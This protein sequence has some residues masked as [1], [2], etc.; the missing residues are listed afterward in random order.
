MLLIRLEG[1]EEVKTKKFNSSTIR[2]LRSLGQPGKMIESQTEELDEKPLIGE[3]TRVLVLR[4]EYLSSPLQGFVAG[5]DYL[6]HC[7]DGMRAIRGDGNCFY[8]AILFGNI[9]ILLHFPLDEIHLQIG[10][11]EKLLEH[12]LS[13][14]Q[15]L[16]KVAETERLRLIE[17][18]RCNYELLIALGYSEFTIEVFYE[19]VMSC[20]VFS[21]S[22]SPSYNDSAGIFRA[23]QQ[24]L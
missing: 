20:N 16:V 19:V 5:I 21:Y 13:G 3:R 23:S 2:V 7:Y 9:H 18:V 11:M 17:T 15:Q 12:F 6:D 14:D 4:N 1:R 22:V 10:F 8:R 24:D